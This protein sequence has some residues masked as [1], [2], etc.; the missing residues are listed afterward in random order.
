MLQGTEVLA[1]LEKRR[2]A[3]RRSIGVGTKPYLGSPFYD[4]DE[5]YKVKYICINAINWHF[6]EIIFYLNN[7]YE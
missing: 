7:Y 4:I 6:I 1:S 5:F 2:R 3:G